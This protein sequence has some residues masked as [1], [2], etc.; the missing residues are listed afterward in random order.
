MM[1]IAI[2]DDELRYTE[3]VFSAIQKWHGI[4]NTKSVT[5]AVF[6]SSEDM[7]EMLAKGLPY[8][9]AFLD[10]QFPGEMNGLELA[11]ILREQNEHIVIVLMTNYHEFAIEGYKVSAIRFLPKPVAEDAVF[12]CLDIAYHQWSL[13]NDKS[14]IIEA[15]QQCYRMPHRNIIYAESRAHYVIVHQLNSDSEVAIRMKLSEF[16]TMLPDEMFIQCHRSYTVNLLHVYSI[17]STFVTMSDGAQIPISPKQWR[18]VHQK[19]KAFYNGGS[20][21]Y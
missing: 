16:N 3:A 8:D 17:S 14:L 21:G 15:G 6:N 11:K 2:C 20:H 12:E 13:I 10:I 4:N 18:T 9:M 19:F 5:A 7:A 1:R